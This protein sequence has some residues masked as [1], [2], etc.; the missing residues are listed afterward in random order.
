MQQWDRTEN[1]EIDLHIYGQ[2]MFSKVAKAIQQGEKKYF[3]QLM[4]EKLN[5]HMPPQKGTS[6]SISEHTEK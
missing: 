3:E 6:T 2:L 4:L 5:I 1:P